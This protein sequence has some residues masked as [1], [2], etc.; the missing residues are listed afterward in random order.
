MAERFLIT[1]GSGFIGT[2]LVEHLRTRRPGAVVRNLDRRPPRNRAHQDLWVK[3]DLCD[4]AG[5]SSAVA[6][7]APTAV[8]HLAARTDL[9]GRAESD[10]M[11]NTEGVKNLVETLRRVKTVRRVVIAS[12][13]LVCP[14][15]YR[16][17]DE[18]DVAP[19]T[20]YGASKVVGERI[21]RDADLPFLWMIVR[22]TS[23]WG[24]WF[25]VPYRDLFTN[26]R[27]GT[28]VHAGRERI[29]KSF[30]YV[31]NTVHQL[32]RLLECG[33]TQMHG[34]TIYLGDY[35]PLEVREFAELIRHEFNTRRIPTVPL[36]IL[37]VAAKVGDFLQYAGWKEP[38]LTSFR[39]TNIRTEMVYDL[40]PL[41]S[42]V[43]PLPYKLDDGVR[44]TV[45]WMR[46]EEK[47]TCRHSE[48]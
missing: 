37:Q 12:S 18:N 38:P 47:N 9:R 19:T 33:W 44:Q 11:A 36:P 35:P 39:L 1:G 8:V 20:A 30:G 4:L 42:V 14:I 26:V 46:N 23:I 45:A 13:R 43:G 17:T 27:R 28:Y 15:G 16:P 3:A 22:P 7:V 21:V 41:A 32:D 10:Y 5:L 34:Q 24:P 25:E 29:T 6:E 2:N 48:S 40:E 31:G